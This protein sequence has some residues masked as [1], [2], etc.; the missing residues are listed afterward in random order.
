MRLA[1]YAYRPCGCT[2]CPFLG[3]TAT[4][5]RTAL[6]VILMKSDIIR[7]G[8]TGLTSYYLTCPHNCYDTCGMVATVEDGVLRSVEGVS[9]HPVTDG[10][11]CAKGYSYVN[12]VY[13]RDRLRHP[14]LQSPRGSGNWR[15]IT[16]DEALDLIARELIEIHR[17]TGSLLPLCLYRGSGN[18][19]VL[20]AAPDAL[21]RAIAPF[22]EAV[23]VLCWATGAEAQ[24][25]DFGD[26]RTSDPTQ[27]K[28]AR[29]LMLWGANPAWTAPHQ[30]DLVMQA[31]DAGAR[32]IAV[33]PLCTATTSRADL[34]LALRPGTDGALALGMAR[35]IL[36]AGLT[37]EAFLQAHTV[38]WAEFRSYLQQS[39]TVEWAAGETGLEPAAIRQAARRLATGGPAMIWIG[40]GMQRY[41]NAGQAIRAI[42]ALAAMTGQIGKPGAGVQYG[43][44]QTQ[45][46]GNY[47]RSF[48]RQPQQPNRQVAMG[49][50]GR[51]LP[52]LQDPPV[53]MLWV[54][55]ANPLCQE[56]ENSLARQALE[57]MRMV[58]V[59][60]QFLTRTAEM[61][62]L[63]LPAA[64]FP[65]Q[66]DLH[67]SYWHHYAAVSQQAIAPRFES[68]SDLQIA[69]M[70]SQAINRLAPGLCQFPTE[71]D[72]REWVERSWY[73][74]TSGLFQGV[75][76]ADVLNRGWVRARLPEVAWSDLDFTTPSGRIE[77]YSQQAVAQGLPGL[78]VYEPPQATPA[79]YPYRLLT[80]H[81]TESLHSQFHGDDWGLRVNPRP[82]AEIHPDTAAALGL[83]DGE[84]A[85][86]YNE[87]GELH[88]PV[89]LTAN[90]QPGTLVAYETFFP[91][92]DYNVNA[93]TKAT[94]RP[95]EGES[96]FPGVAYA[97]CF[98]AVEPLFG[99]R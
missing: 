81:S 64:T 44:L 33:D 59:V 24:R 41:A 19:G 62:D 35:A 46:F 53:E 9:H 74:D 84:M 67:V 61:A 86:L 50:I 72:E 75:T 17:R 98:V 94:P 6:Y 32:I 8:A 28:S 27:I 49:A 23:N 48:D 89:R 77:L 51:V 22:T 69:W 34:H 99:R 36:D 14:M 57:A 13:A 65:A 1:P 40:F 4:G 11:L 66:W 5:D 25:L 16:W 90:V 79:A 96:A 56:P 54:A 26:M 12:R 38:G 73:S 95:A 80:P 45:V 37:D 21:F 55:A 20:H 92:L 97:D 29:T 31:Q 43:H 18:L 82:V 52:E 63:V 7:Q 87:Q 71:G 42:D 30:M 39:V 2:L 83:A 68:R 93:L 15:R 88:L 10:R 60:D 47:L 85:R 78:P 70:L 91:G 3:R 58:V 76:F